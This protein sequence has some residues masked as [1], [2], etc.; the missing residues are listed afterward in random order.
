MSQQKSRTCRATKKRRY[1]DHQEAV[2]AVQSFQAKSTRDR[3]PTDAYP[4]DAC[5]GWHITSTPWS[6]N[7]KRAA[8]RR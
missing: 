8:T 1:R 2:R 4:C 5:G 3:V 6:P 7:A